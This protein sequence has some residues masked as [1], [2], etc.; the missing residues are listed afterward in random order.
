MSLVARPD[1]RAETLRRVSLAAMLDYLAGN[2]RREIPE[3]EQLSAVSAENLHPESLVGSLLLANLAGI[4][5]PE[6]LVVALPADLAERHPD[7]LAGK[8][9]A[10]PAESHH[11]VH[12]A[13]RMAVL[14]VESRHRGRLVVARAVEIHHL[15][16]P[17]ARQPEVSVEHHRDRPAETQAVRLAGRLLV[18]HLGENHPRAGRL[19]VARLAENHPRAERLLAAL[20]AGTPAEAPHQ[21]GKSVAE[22]TEAGRL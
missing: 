17:E 2:L 11:R 21:G 6:N 5:R 15:V 20:P 4:R 8:M 7:R 10:L 9:A 3:E 13:E 12:L 1:L 14:P 19:L 18:A 22:K 16:R